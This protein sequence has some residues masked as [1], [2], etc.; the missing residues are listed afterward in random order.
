MKTDGCLA[1]NNVPAGIIFRKQVSNYDI[2]FDNQN[3]LLIEFLQK[4]VYN[5]SN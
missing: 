1:L 5:P 3:L 4:T 2:I